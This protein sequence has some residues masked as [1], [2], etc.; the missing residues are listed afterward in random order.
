MRGGSAGISVRGPESHEG[1]CDSLMYPHSLSQRR[2]I[3]I[4]FHFLGGILNYFWFI[5]KNNCVKITWTYEFCLLIITHIDIVTRKDIIS[6][7]NIY[8]LSFRSNLC[9]FL[10][11]SS[12]SA[13]VHVP[14]LLLFCVVVV[15]LF[16]FVLCLVP[17]FA[18]V[19]GLPFLD[20][21]F[22]FLYRLCTSI[23]F[24]FFASCLMIQFYRPIY[25]LITGKNL[26]DAG[27]NKYPVR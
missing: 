4:F 13:W 19:S 2:F 9:K 16:V 22:C 25:S 10:F 8:L 27:Q 21:H 11:E 23:T 12:V 7:Y 17:Q 6:L 20:C 1:A 14:H 15:V 5:Q 3:L 24:F 18:C 26:E